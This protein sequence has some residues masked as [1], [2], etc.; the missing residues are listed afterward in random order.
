MSIH[1]SKLLSS[2]PADACLDS[3]AQI[4]RYIYTWCARNG[5]VI[6]YHQ[7]ETVETNLPYHRAQAQSTEAT[8]LGLASEPTSSSNQPVQNACSPSYSPVPCDEEATERLLCGLQ[9][10]QVL[11]EHSNDF[12]FEIDE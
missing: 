8:P 6:S 5:V 1:F 7:C 2:I 11:S 10:P 4:R 9:S 12:D 3:S